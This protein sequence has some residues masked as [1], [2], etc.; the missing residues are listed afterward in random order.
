ME[1]PDRETPKPSEQ[2]DVIP[3][4]RLKSNQL[5]L[6]SVLNFKQEIE[7]LIEKYLKKS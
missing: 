3:I 2:P 1:N 4:I 5:E 7:E 6:N